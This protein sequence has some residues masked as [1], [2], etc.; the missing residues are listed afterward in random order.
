MDNC[1][2]TTLIINRTLHLIVSCTRGEQTFLMFILASLV[3]LPYNGVRFHCLNSSLAAERENLILIIFCFHNSSDRSYLSL[4]PC[5]LTKEGIQR[6]CKILPTSKSS[7]YTVLD[8][9]KIS[10][11]VPFTP[12]HTAILLALKPWTVPN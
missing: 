10:Q 7:T 3:Y 1:I 8:T 9:K 11:N 4:S 2:S 5:Q 12:G 6:Y